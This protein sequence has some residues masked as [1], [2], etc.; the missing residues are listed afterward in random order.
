MVLKQGLKSRGS[1]VIIITWV[2]EI[3]KIVHKFPCVLTWMMGVVRHHCQHF[4][5]YRCTR[6]FF[7]CHGIYVIL[8]MLTGLTRNWPTTTLLRTMVIVYN[9]LQQLSTFMATNLSQVCQD[10]IHNFTVESLGK[11]CAPDCYGVVTDYVENTCNS[12]FIAR[13]CKQSTVLSW[14]CYCWLLLPYCHQ[15]DIL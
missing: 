4:L 15:P 1:Y 9:P 12:S 11:I 7:T 3:K 2:R 10:A 6:M 14:G 5:Y 13:T 8:R